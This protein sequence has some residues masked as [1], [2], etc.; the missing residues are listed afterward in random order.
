[1]I[2]RCELVD[3]RVCDFCYVSCQFFGVFRVMCLVLVEDSFRVLGFN[4]F[5]DGCNFGVGVGDKV[6][7]CN[8]YRYVKGFDVV[9]VMVEVCVVVLNCLYVFFVQIC[10]CYVIV[11][12]YCVYSGYQNYIIGCEVCFVIFDVY[13]FFSIKVC[14]KVCFG[15][16]VVCYFKCGFSCD[17]RVVVVCDVCEWVVVDKGRVVFQCLYEVWL[18]CVF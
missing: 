13:E 18:Y 12:F 11:Y 5:F 2:K 10:F 16:D 3:V 15:Y 7:D 9:D 4:V 8:D 1:M 17:N 14:V 6:V